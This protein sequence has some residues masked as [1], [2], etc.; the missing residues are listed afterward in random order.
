ML[1]HNIDKQ[2]LSCRRIK[3]R[4]LLTKSLKIS[5]QMVHSEQ[6]LKEVIEIPLLHSGVAINKMFTAATII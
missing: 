1:L 6:A 3:S 5:M 4:I 2:Q